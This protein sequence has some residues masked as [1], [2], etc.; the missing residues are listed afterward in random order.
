[1]F[2]E[3]TTPLAVQ[4][5]PVTLFALGVFFSSIAI[6]L[7]ILIFN[8]QGGI[9]TIILS[10][11]AFI[12]LLYTS[13][14]RE[15]HYDAT[16]NRERTLLKQHGKVIF[17]LLF[18]FLGNVVSF[19]G[20]SLLLPSH[21]STPLFEMQHRAIITT[22]QHITGSSI[23]PED[24]LLPILHKNFSVMLFAFLLSIFFGFGSLYIVIWNA[25]V[26]AIAMTTFVKT[27]MSPLGISIPLSFLRYLTHGLPEIIGFFIAG[28]AGGIMY[29]AFIRGD[30]TRAH[31][32][33]IYKDI[34]AL[35]IY[36]C[37]FIIMAGLIEVYVTPLFFP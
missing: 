10:V 32:H 31:A 9:N 33:T 21:L 5:K 1:M 8:N 12:P 29:I 20:W 11:L 16:H 13:I 6:L 14:K 19:F 3:L 23:N 37:F 18:I 27:S 17:F 15:E 35:T 30:L 22:Q 34:L 7:S 24:T 25:S 36:A 28:L 2:K 4:H 26:V